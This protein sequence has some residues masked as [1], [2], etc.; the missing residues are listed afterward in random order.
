M[1]WA[2]GYPRRSKSGPSSFVCFAHVT[3]TL[4]RTAGKGSRKGGDEW[5]ELWVSVVRESR[6]VC[7]AA[8]L[9]ASSS[10]P[11]GP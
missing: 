9:A 2:P 7:S 3:K 10:R 8:V 1:A 6:P 5:S 11:S 4:S